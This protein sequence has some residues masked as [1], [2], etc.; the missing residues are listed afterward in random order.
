M[1]LSLPPVPSDDPPDDG[2]VGFSECVTPTVGANVVGDGGST[3]A[4]VV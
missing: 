4:G 1:I 3:C 2:A